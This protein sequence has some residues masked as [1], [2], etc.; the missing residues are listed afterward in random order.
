MPKE[1]EKRSKRGK[2]AGGRR[3]LLKRIKDDASKFLTSEEGKVVRK[4]I[5]KAA[6]ALGLMAGAAQDAAAQ[7]HSD[8]HADSTIQ[9]GDAITHQLHNDSA[10]GQY[11]HNS[12]N[13]INAPYSHSDSHADHSS[14]SSHGNH[15]AHGSGGWC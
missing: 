4:D 1:N 12:G 7:S 13:H 15:S 5:V 8:S 10:S 11:G 6:I 2:K 3:R 14:H 9:H